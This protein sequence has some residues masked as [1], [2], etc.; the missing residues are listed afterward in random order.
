[1]YLQPIEDAL[2]RSAFGSV[3]RAL[4]DLAPVY[5]PPSQSTRIVLLVGRI[6]LGNMP[7]NTF[8]VPPSTSTYYLANLARFLWM[9]SR[10][11]F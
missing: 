6:C 10:R 9:I 4:K 2:A 1:M 3:Q 5:K 11:S 7:D 8:E